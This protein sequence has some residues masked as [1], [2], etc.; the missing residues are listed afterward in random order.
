M[1]DDAYTI[2][3]TGLDK[4]LA[5]LK[6]KAPVA[7]VGILGGGSSR[8]TKTSKAHPTTNAEVGAVQEFGSIS[9]GIVARSFLRIP[10]SENLQKYMEKS[11]A[12]DFDTINKVLKEGTVV[13]WLKKVVV[14]AE[15]IVSDAFDSG[16]FGKWAPWKNPSYTNETGQ[17]LVDTQQ[18]RNSITSE[19]KE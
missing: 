18:L 4:L 7:R 8:E 1:S 14:L 11:G 5:S 17:I 15:S 13:P 3:T 10:I 9:Q 2:K 6:Q 16:G 19:V 12:F